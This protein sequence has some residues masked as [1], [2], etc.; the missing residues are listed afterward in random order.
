MKK[1]TLLSLFLGFAMV[2]FSN[3]NP[4]ADMTKKEVNI[5]KSTVIWK[6]DKVIGS[7]HEGT[8]NLKSGSLKYDA[9][10]MLAGGMFTIDMTSIKTTDLSGNMAAK[11]EGH[12]K[13]D[14]F[15]GVETFPTADF[16]ITTVDVTDKG[17]TI[18]G[19]LTIKGNTHPVS[20]E[21][22]MSETGAAAIIQ[23]DRT[24]YDVRYGSGKFFDNLG[25]KTIKD[26]FDLEVSLVFAG[27]Q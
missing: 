8:V 12:L 4:A 9:A 20:F 17:T 1:I 27:D 22:R 3:G 18:S 14:D 26:I 24:L 10:G 2:A 6:A 19:N 13:S 23:V 16:E 25:D 11:L 15:F 7:G 5:E 21:A